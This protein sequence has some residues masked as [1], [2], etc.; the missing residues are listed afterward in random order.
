MTEKIQKAINK[1][2]S[3]AEKHNDTIAKIIASHIID[4]YLNSDEN[5]E[6]VLDENHTLKKCLDKIKSKARKQASNGMAVIEDDTVYNWAKE[7]YGFAVGCKANK[8]IDL[9]DVIS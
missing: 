9:F 3:E 5:A 7:Y 1:I 8:I 2:D 6:K 4:N